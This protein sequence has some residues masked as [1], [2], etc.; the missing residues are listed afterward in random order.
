[1][2]NDLS[3]YG[4]DLRERVLLEVGT[5]WL[6]TMSL[7]AALLGASVHTYDHVVH[8]REANLRHVL[9]LLGPQLE[10]IAVTP[11]CTSEVFLA[12]HLRRFRKAAGPDV[13]SWLAACGV[14]YHAPAD[15]AATQMAAGS[16]DVHFSLNVLEHVPRATVSALFRE[17]YRVLKPGGLVRHRIDTSDHYA[18]GDR[19]IT[20]INFLKY[21]DLTWR[22][23]GQNRI[24]FTNRLRKSEYLAEIE[25]AGLDIL[26]CQAFVDDKSV[27]ALSRGP[28]NERYRHMDIAD[29]ATSYF[30]V[31][32]RKP[33][34]VR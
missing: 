22:I 28:L 29:L 16:V 18:H 3:R 10:E 25:A 11:P 6:P 2:V 20:E 5:G 33:I 8:L 27:S 30:T 19:R 1:M 17:A 12:N 15:A 21:S 34:R 7:G 32:A 31:I 26:D 13:A 23:I 9:N 14:Y 24:H 4:G